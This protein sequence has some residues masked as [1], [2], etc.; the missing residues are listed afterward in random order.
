MI[1]I[2]VTIAAINRKAGSDLHGSCSSR[3]HKLLKKTAIHEREN[4]REDRVQHY[5]DP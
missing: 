1:G 2:S 3:R 5:D 4:I